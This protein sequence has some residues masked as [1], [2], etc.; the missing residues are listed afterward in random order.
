MLGNAKCCH[1]EHNAVSRARGERKR[2]AFLLITLLL[3][4]RQ[5]LLMTL[6]VKDGGVKTGYLRIK[7][8]AGWLPFQ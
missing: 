5:G 2:R 4:A 1:F 7:A 8:A 6:V 3:K